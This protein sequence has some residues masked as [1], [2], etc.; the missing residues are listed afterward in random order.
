MPLVTLE[1]PLLESQ[2]FSPLEADLEAE[3]VIS[4]TGCGV[5]SLKSVASFRQKILEVSSKAGGNR[6]IT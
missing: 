4:S 6:E 5:S 3:V 2:L 1:S